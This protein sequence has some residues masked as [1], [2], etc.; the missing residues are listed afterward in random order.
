V[1]VI[2]LRLEYLK[3]L[4]EIDKYHSISAAAKSLFISQTTLSSIVKSLE[5]D[6]GLTVF[7]R[8]PGGVVT[9]PD[10]EELLSLAWDINVKFEEIEKLKEQY[11]KASQPV[12]VI[13]SPSISCGLSNPS[14]KLMLEAEPFANL[15]FE[16]FSGEQIGAKIIQNVASIGLTYYV[17]EGLSEYQ[18]AAG[19]YN[20]QVKKMFSDHLYLLA[21]GDHPLAK[22]ETVDVTEISGENMAMLSHFRSNMNNTLVPRY[23]WEKNRAT[24]FSSVPLIKSAIARHNMLSILSGY[25]IHYSHNPSQSD[26]RAVLLTTPTGENKMSLCL[27]HHGNRSLGYLEKVMISCVEDYFSSI[28]PPPFSPQAKRLANL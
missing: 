3:Y 6:L 2:G 11:K 7:E 8:T 18:L 21:R 19:K 4:I 26:Y 17:K 25:A 28:M 10:G 15:V 9:T 14:S 1:E 20:I 22:R 24:T 13:T 5:R 16:D 27:I 23:L 12:I